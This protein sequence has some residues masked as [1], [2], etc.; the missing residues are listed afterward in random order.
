[1]VTTP[2]LLLCSVNSPQWSIRAKSSGQEKGFVK[3][4]SIGQTA[5]WNFPMSILAN[6]FASP[7]AST[8]GMFWDLHLRVVSSP[9]G[10][11]QIKRCGRQSRC[12]GAV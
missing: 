5:N 6:G 7:T 1:M 4:W 2:A 3:A 10:R 12:Y 8:S 9:R 11:R